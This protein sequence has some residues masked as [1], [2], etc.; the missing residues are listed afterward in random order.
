MYTTTR[1]AIKDGLR[2]LRRQL[3]VSTPLNVLNASVPTQDLAVTRNIVYG[4]HIRKRLDVYRP[5]DIAGRLPVIIFFYGGK[6]MRGHRDD[7]LFAAQCLASLGYVVVVPDYRLHPEVTFPGFVHDGAAAVAWAEAHVKDYRGDPN[8]LFLMG[9]SAGAYIAS[10]LAYDRSYL[11]ERNVDHSRIKGLVGM[12]GPYNFLSVLQDD[13]DLVAVFGRY[14]DSE[15]SQ[16][17]TFVSEEAPPSLFIT[18][19]DDPIVSPDNAYSTAARLEALGV[20]AAV[21]AYPGIGHAGTVLALAHRF[22]WRAGVTEDIGIF[23]E[24][25]AGQ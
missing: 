5:T 3:L 6:W 16:P 15:L 10:K 2:Y 20:E 23:L 11:D 9:H 14:A 4:Q 24:Q 12:S 17:V 22:R 13:P 18:G 21:Q 8:R 7:Y 25:H 19:E 1:S